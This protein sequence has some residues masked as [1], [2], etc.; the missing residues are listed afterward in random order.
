MKIGDTPSLFKIAPLILPTPRFLWKKSEPPSV[1][2]F[3][4]LNTTSLYKE[5]GP[6]GGVFQIC[7]T[8]SSITLKK[9][10]RVIRS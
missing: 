8:S 5:G 2:K 9:Y 1:Q 6:G 3:Q 7:T 4:T 10:R